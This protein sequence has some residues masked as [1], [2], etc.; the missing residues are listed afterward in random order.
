VILKYYLT[1]KD[2]LAGKPCAEIVEYCE[3]YAQL[4]MRH[5]LEN[6]AYA[7]ECH[8]VETTTFRIWRADDVKYMVE[9]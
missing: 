9:T 8:R 2:W 7:V 5:A 4:C 1:H 3:S 6:G